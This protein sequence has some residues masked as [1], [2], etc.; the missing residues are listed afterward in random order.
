MNPADAGFIGARQRARF[1]WL[2]GTAVQA[3]GGAEVSAASETARPRL[4]VRRPR[5]VFILPKTH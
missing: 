1:A 2:N 5:S 4:N 3:R